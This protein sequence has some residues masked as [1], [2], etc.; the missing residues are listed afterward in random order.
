MCRSTL[1][2]PAQAD[3][4][5]FGQIPPDDIVG[6]TVILL[7]CS[8]REK[9]GRPLGRGGKHGEEACLRWR[10]DVAVIRLTALMNTCELHLQTAGVHAPVRAHCL[11]SVFSKCRSS[12]TWA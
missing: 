7:T 11:Q 3:P 8:Y 10:A 5:E 6:V 1:C 12:S 9:V 4:P 2:P